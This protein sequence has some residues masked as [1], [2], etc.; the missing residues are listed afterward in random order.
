M[1]HCLF[2]NFRRELLWIY[3]LYIWLISDLKWNLKNYSFL[4]SSF[5]FYLI[6]GGGGG[7]GV[8]ES[9]WFKIL[10]KFYDLIEILYKCNRRYVITMVINIII[11]TRNIPAKVDF[12]RRLE[13]VF[14]RGVG[15][16]S[17]EGRRMV[18][19]L[20]FT[21]AKLMFLSLFLVAIAVHVFLRSDCTRHCHELKWQGW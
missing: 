2:I 7:V 18:L 1:L 12:R 5:L 16:S 19:S 15:S 9:L 8:T 17:S 21:S 3:C 4:L 20:T 13:A 6:I 10:Y 14:S 11:I